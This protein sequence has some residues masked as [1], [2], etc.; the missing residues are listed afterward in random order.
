MGARTPK[1]ENFEAGLRGRSETYAADGYA[2]RCDWSRQGSR[3]EL[4][5]SEIPPESGGKTAPDSEI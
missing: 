1:R 5:F 3:E 2:L 4:Q